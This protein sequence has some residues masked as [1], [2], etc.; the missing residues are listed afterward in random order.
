MNKIS[1]WND[2]EVKKLF[3]MV[4]K[5]KQ[6]NSSLLDAFRSYAKKT[7]RKPN[8]V[9]NYYYQEISLLR[10]N[11]E[12]A[13]A[14]GIDVSLHEINNSNKFSKDETKKLVK[15]ILRQ[16]CMG[17][18][19]RKACL[20]LAKNDVNKMV[21]YQNKFRSIAKFDKELY[22]QCFTEL[23]EEGLVN[24]EEK[25]GSNVIYMKKQPERKLSDEDVNSLFLGLIKLVKKTA[26]ED[27]EKELSSEAEFANSTLR[28]TLT[29]LAVAEK[30]ID[31]L[32]EKLE[33]AE[34]NI[35]SLQEE[36]MQLKTKIATYLSE[37]LVKTNKNKSLTKYLR[38]MK[39]KGNEVKT[40]I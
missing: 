33:M 17:V 34:L 36:N 14:L 23:K 1:K 21:R 30:T 8:S 35:N 20:N 7:N 12:R 39:E 22:N 6:E 4:E 19:V 10:N 40:K 13:K 24:K 5:T 2:K 28:K 37:K 29:K 11:P 27:V 9:R 31:T 16:K 3:L 15:A 18:S 25:K 26:V 32:S 38:D